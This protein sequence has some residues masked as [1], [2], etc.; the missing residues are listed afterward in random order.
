M[1][2]NMTQR[3]QHERLAGKSA[4]ETKHGHDHLSELPRAVLYFSLLP[5]M[6]KAS[7]F[8]LSFVSTMHT[9]FR[10]DPETD[11]FFNAGRP[12]LLR[13]PHMV[14]SACVMHRRDIFG[15]DIPDRYINPDKQKHFMSVSDA[16]WQDSTIQSDEADSVAVSA[17]NKL[18]D[19]EDFLLSQVMRHKNMLKQ[20][21]ATARALFVQAH[22]LCAHDNLACDT[23]VR[24]HIKEYHFRSVVFERPEDFST[25]DTGR[26]RR[27]YVHMEAGSFHKRAPWNPNTDQQLQNSSS[28]V[29][30]ILERDYVENMIPVYSA[31]TNRR[32]T[33]ESAMIDR[34]D[35]VSP[36]VR[37]SASVVADKIGL[38][39]TLQS[40]RLLK[41][42][43]YQ[44]EAERLYTAFDAV[45][46]G[47]NS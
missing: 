38:V 35:V 14:S 1:S 46:E 41:K 44:S 17:M 27:K 36:T 21:K 3:L 39:L 19:I 2:N 43:V 23:F 6:S 31:L 29:F 13:F 20:E 47:D 24:T 25:Y 5:F 8:S 40:V 9:H 22:P 34:G 30:N 33:G 4:F 37:I 42:A 15:R 16:G 28:P 11:M 7:V 26:A 18:F 45:I 32:L 12:L 10:V